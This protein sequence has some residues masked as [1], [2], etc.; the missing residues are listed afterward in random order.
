MFPPNILL[1]LD[2][3][4]ACSLAQTQGCESWYHFEGKKNILLHLAHVPLT[5]YFSHVLAFPVSPK[6]PKWVLCIHASSE[7]LGC[8][9]VF[10][11]QIP[12]RS[13]IEILL[14]YLFANIIIFI[15]AKIIFLKELSIECR[16]SFLQKRSLSRSW[17]PYLLCWMLFLVPMS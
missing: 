8:L 17:C 11:H 1:H 12:T 14:H 6:K 3:A 5:I 10:R 4:I 7:T 9:P 13:R 2:E 15:G 16:I